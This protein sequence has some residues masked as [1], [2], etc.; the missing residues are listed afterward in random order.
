VSFKVYDDIPNKIPHLWI[1]QSQEYVSC[2]TF[3]IIMSDLSTLTFNLCT[4][5]QFGWF[6]LFV[7]SCSVC[8]VLLAFSVNCITFGS[9]LINY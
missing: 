7:C 6:M 4:Y 9:L 5:R 3:M 8:T 1:L 2:V